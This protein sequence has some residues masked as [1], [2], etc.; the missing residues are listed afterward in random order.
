MVAGGSQGLGEAP[1]PS[2]AAGG[3]PRIARIRAKRRIGRT[4]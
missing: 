3:D 4:A 2:A 1:G